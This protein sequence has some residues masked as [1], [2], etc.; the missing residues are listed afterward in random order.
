MANIYKSKVKSL[1]RKYGTRD[2][3]TIAK[4]MGITIKLQHLNENVPKGMFK[5]ILKRKFIIINMTRITDNDDFNVVMAH[6]LGH[7][8]LHSSD[9]SFFLHD[10]SLYN[11]GKFEYQANIFAAE[12][13]IPDDSFEG[14][15]I[16]NFP[17]QLFE[18]KLINMKK[19]NKIP[20]C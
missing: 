19:D 7:A 14:D 8:V 11:R 12:L 16:N 1:T 17:Q 15:N 4:E 20:N 9:A 2:P 6:E 10:H 18:F 5:K 3:L 13:L